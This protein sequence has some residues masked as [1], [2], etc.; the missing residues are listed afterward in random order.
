MNKVLDYII[1]VVSLIALVLAVVLLDG[2]FHITHYHQQQ[3]TQQATWRECY[4]HTCVVQTWRNQHKA[5]H[6]KPITIQVTLPITQP[7]ESDTIVVP[8]PTPQP[9]Q[10]ATSNGPLP[11]NP[12]GLSAYDYV[13]QYDC[14]S[15]ADDQIECV[16]D[17]GLI[18]LSCGTVTLITQ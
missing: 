4:E 3:E 12:L 1:L 18:I 16:F 2:V 8:S 5:L 10:Q 6:Q 9:T 17:N 11:D 7:L 14:T 13:S 15:K